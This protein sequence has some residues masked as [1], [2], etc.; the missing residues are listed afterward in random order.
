[1]FKMKRSV[2]YLYTPTE[3]TGMPV[4]RNDKRHTPKIG[5][6]PLRLFRQRENLPVFQSEQSRVL[7]IMSG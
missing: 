1:M 7:L 3:G 6:M 2:T 4:D 5:V